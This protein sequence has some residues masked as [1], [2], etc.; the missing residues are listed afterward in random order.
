MFLLVATN[1]SSVSATKNSYAL[2]SRYDVASYEIAEAEKVCNHI[3]YRSGQM[4]FTSYD[5]YGSASTESNILLAASG[6]DA[7]NA[8]VFYIGHGA[9]DSYLIFDDNGAYV[10]YDEVYAVTGAQRTKFVFLWSCYQAEVKDRMPKGWLHT[11]SVSDDGYHNPDYGGL[12]FIG[13]KGSAPFISLKIGDRDKA[14]AKFINVTYDVL[15]VGTD[16]YVNEALNIAS[17]NVWGVVWDKSPLY[18]VYGMW[19]Y[20]DGSLSVYGLSG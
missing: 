14:G 5:W 11:T 20:G 10:W 13:F 3:V 16:S 8:I 6:N 15:A 18:E 19:V 12:T 9:D 2:G 7:N 4:G 17:I 1:I